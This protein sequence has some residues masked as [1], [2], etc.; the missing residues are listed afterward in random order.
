MDHAS[1]R[2][3]SREVVTLSVAGAYA[4]LHL[5]TSTAYVTQPQPKDLTQLAN[6]RV[7]AAQ[8]RHLSGESKNFRSGV[9]AAIAGGGALTLLL[10]HGRRKVSEPHRCSVVRLAAAETSEKDSS[11]NH[12]IPNI[13]VPVV[14]GA[15]ATLAAFASDPAMAQEVV[16]AVAEAA[17]DVA[18]DAEEVVGEVAQSSGDWFEPLIQFNAG[19]IAG[20]DGVIEDQLHIPNSFGFAIIG[21]TLLIK[22]LTYPLNQSA[23]RSGAIMQL[24]KP[25]VDQIQRKYKN[26]QETQNRMMLR[27]YDDCGV[28]PLGGCIPSLL[29]FPIYI[30]LYR[31]IQ[32]LSQINPKFQ[33]PFLW[34]PSLAGPTAG[35]PNLDWLVKSQSADEFI[36]LI[37]WTDAARYC[38]LPVLLIGSQIVTQKVSQPEVGNQGGPA[39]IVQNVIPLVIGYTGLVSPA[40]L[41]VYWLCN[42]LLTQA[43]TY[44]IRSQLGEEFPEYKKV[45]DGTY[46]QEAEE[47]RKRKEQEKQEEELSAPGR[48]F[49]QSLEEEEKEE[50][51]ENEADAK[52]LET[53]PA[54]PMR[55]LSTQARPRRRRSRR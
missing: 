16:G 4:L 10:R 25:K 33:E 32:K 2:G 37:G 5:S 43:Q 48:G 52:E 26:D 38:V 31:S 22:V 36:P 27:L 50:E 9:G 44:V 30:G 42:N 15:L 23:L 17:A 19:I 3:I 34:I 11:Q 45:L 41:G 12:Q 35:N 13:P 39:A 7:S 29:Q 40:G 8:T 28:N 51:E 53:E 20:I 14:A 46:E 47:E 49:G 24:I 18:D 1:R 55:R 21:Y 54:R 6:L